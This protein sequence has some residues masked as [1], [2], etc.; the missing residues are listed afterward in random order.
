[1]SEYPQIIPSK[2]GYKVQI[3]ERCAMPGVY[4]SLFLAE[5]ALRRHEGMKAEAK[6]AKRKK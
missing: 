5:R 2:S 6:E 4:T 3:S 1:M